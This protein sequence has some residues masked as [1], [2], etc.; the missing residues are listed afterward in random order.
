VW[1]VVGG[2]YASSFLFAMADLLNQFVC[3]LPP[4]TESVVG[5]GFF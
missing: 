2:Y 3:P 4:D 5:E 1:W